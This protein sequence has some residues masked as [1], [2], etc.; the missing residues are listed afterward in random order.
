[1]NG[2]SALR[3]GLTILSELAHPK[4]QAQTNIPS[5]DQQSETNCKQEKGDELC[6][7][8][9]TIN[10]VQETCRLSILLHRQTM[11]ILSWKES[12]D[13]HQEDTLYIGVRV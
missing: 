13:L 5:W 11:V 12:A 4:T 1:M 3:I 2:S 7:M 9:A 10:A 8:V 6:F